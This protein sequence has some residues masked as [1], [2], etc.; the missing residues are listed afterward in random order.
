MGDQL[1]Q[2]LSSLSNEQQKAHKKGLIEAFQNLFKSSSSTKHQSK[3]R[4]RTPTADQKRA[5]EPSSSPA[6]NSS[7]QS[8]S[9]TSS[10]LK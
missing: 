4:T 2:K 9:Q 5:P 7:L 6:I 3:E 8:G 10:Q 1:N